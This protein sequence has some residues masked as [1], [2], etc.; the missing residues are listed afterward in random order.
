MTIH[1]E[2]RL[3]E[4][5]TLRSRHDRWGTLDTW[6]FTGDETGPAEFCAQRW[7]DDKAISAPTYDELLDRLNNVPQ[8]DRDLT[9]DDRARIDKLA[10]AA[11][12]A[13]ERQLGRKPREM[14]HNNEGYDIE[15]ADPKEPGRLRFIEVKGKAVGKT[16]VTISATQIRHCCNQPDTGI[17]AIVQTD[18]D[19]AQ[20]P[21]Y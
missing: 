15:S 3:R 13:A 2:Q 1:T 5:N 18:G 4:G 16:T 19:K 11:V 10:V 6:Y 14:Q 21:R 20:E 17:R 9:P 12:M 8:E 7:S